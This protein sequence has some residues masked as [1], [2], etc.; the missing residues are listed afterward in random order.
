MFRNRLVNTMKKQEEDELYSIGEMSRAFDVTPRALRFYEDKGL[1]S[2]FRS[3][4]ARMYSGRDRARLKLILRGKRVGLTLMEIR[5]LLDLYNAP[6]GKNAQMRR[7]LE[8]YK[9]QAEM[10]VQQR[11]EIDAALI[12]L[13]N[14]V[15]SMEAQ[16]ALSADEAPEPVKA[17][18]AKIRKGQK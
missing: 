16:L 3:G 8:K 1:L 14:E 12:E 5:E 6:D 13:H 10:L 18:P 11:A 9:S 17:R 4:A 2:P 7:T 15:A